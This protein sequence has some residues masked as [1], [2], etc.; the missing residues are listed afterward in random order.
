MGNAVALRSAASMSIVFFG[1]RRASEVAALDLSEAC[2]DLTAGAVDISVRRQ[3]NDQSGAG[4]LARIVSLPLREG[5]CPVRLLS[6]WARLRKWLPDHREK[7]RRLAGAEGRGPLFAGLARA[8]FG[9][10]MAAAGMSASRKKVLGG[11]GLAPRKEGTRSYLMDGMSRGATQELG[12]WRTPGVMETVHN[13]ALTEEVAP[14]MRPA[15]KKARSW[16]DAQA[17]VVDLDSDS[18]S[19]GEE[20]VGS[21][22]GAAVRVW[23]HRFCAL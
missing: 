20:A 8:R 18:C 21:E 5:A 7:T 15:I 10:G 17:L 23:F 11:R 6:G 22:E 9:L 19:D 3:K 13:K 2:V 12:G 14:E 4:R 1:P 16:M